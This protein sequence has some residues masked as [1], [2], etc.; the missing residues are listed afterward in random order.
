MKRTILPGAYRHLSRRRT[1]PGTNQYAAKAPDGPPSPDE[2]QTTIP[3]RSSHSPSSFGAFPCKKIQ[4]YVTEVIGPTASGCAEVPAPTVRESAAAQQGIQA[5][6]PEW[7]A[8]Y[9][10]AYLAASTERLRQGVRLCRPYSWRRGRP[11]RKGLMLALPVVF[12]L[13]E[14]LMEY[15][16]AK[17]ISFRKT[18]GSIFASTSTPFVKG[19][20]FCP[21]RE[22]LKHTQGD[23]PETQSKKLA[24]ALKS[25]R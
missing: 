20:N 6:H 24:T 5:G 25:C 13:V 17:N 18:T 7:E 21:F 14:Y 16:M 11:G 15:L 23:S 9:T 8:L 1:K 2:R 3:G 12:L 10:R 19:V 22:S 4:R